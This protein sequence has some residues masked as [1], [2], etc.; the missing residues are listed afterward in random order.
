MPTFLAEEA[1]RDLEI[2][3]IVTSEAVRALAPAI[4]QFL[5]TLSRGLQE[6]LRVE[7]RI[8]GRNPL[9]PHPQKRVLEPNESL[10]VQLITHRISI[11]NGLRNHTILC[12][13]L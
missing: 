8:A 4:C 7:I 6:L 1:N 2:R 11:R 13:G 3:G 10:I 9:K 5:G 12:S